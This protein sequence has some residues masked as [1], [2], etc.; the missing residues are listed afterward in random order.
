MSVVTS[1]F[2]AA[3]RGTY[4]FLR[5]A[6]NTCHVHLVADVDA[7][8]LKAA[9]TSSGGKL[10]YASFVVKAGADVIADCP[11]AR[12]VLTG[13]TGRP[14][15][16]VLDEVHAKV[17]FDK[18]ADGTRCVVSGIVT[19]AQNRSVLEVQTEL[20]GYKDAEVTDPEGPFRNV[21]RVARLPIPLAWLAYRLATRNPVRRTELGGVFSVTSVGH[22]PV[23]SILPMITGS[24]G[25]GVGRIADTPVVRG[26][27]VVVAPVL[28]LSLTFDHRILDGALAAELLARTKDKLEHWEMP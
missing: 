11:P 21:L 15:L 19:S 23:R 14:K 10:S 28:T 20:D 1:A 17:L 25:F 16:A 5:D 13:S 6:R 8:R 18:T 26:G 4:T 12:S 9:R 2:P 22:E 27:E 3:R 7:T 24:L